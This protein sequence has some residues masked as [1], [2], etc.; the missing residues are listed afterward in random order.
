MLAQA[1]TFVKGEEGYCPGIT[2]D[3]NP[4]DDRSVLVAN[5]ANGTGSTAWTSVF[6]LEV[7]MDYLPFLPL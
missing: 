7:L 4:A 6:A 3:K 2:A 5:P 1:L